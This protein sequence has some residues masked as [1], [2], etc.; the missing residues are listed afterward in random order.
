MELFTEMSELY[1][2][3]EINMYTNKYVLN[4]TSQGNRYLYSVDAKKIFQLDE[5]TYKYLEKNINNEMMLPEVIKVNQEDKSCFEYIEFSDKNFLTI[6][7]LSKL[8]LV[9]TNDC[10][11]NCS[12]CYA[13]GGSYGFKP[14]YM[15][16][17]VIDQLFRFLSENE[18][19]VK[20]LML[21]GG[22]PLLAMEQINDVMDSIQ[23]YKVGI[24]QYLM[25]TN[26]TILTDEE[27]D[28]LI[29]KNVH[30]TVSLDGNKIINDQLRKYKFNK[31][32]S[33]FDE[34][35]K[36]I[37]RF[38][39][40]GGAIESIEST[41]TKKHEMLN[42]SKNDVIN[43][44]KN[45]F[46]IENILIYDVI[47]KKRND[48]ISFTE[49]RND[50]NFLD[51]EHLHPNDLKCINKLFNISQH[52]YQI[53]EAGNTILTIL[54]NGEVYPCQLLINSKFSLGNVT[55]PFILNKEKTKKYNTMV[56]SLHSKKECENCIARN[57]C[58]Y[59]LYFKLNYSSQELCN[60]MRNGM[61]Q[62]L[63]HI[64]DNRVLE[65]LDELIR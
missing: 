45:E 49:L 53:C 5:E 4:E 37:N 59:C 44:I 61:I 46:Q 28:F 19:S 20:N 21:F 41:Y 62:D 2:N 55:E 17:Q 3:E 60:L 25:V 7:E 39:T 64:I 15:S 47:D 38:R 58:T 29:N 65:R 40:A 12:Y 22:E 32:K 14:E 34:V 33:T 42:I 36:N 1:I 31:N 6:K 9:L 18:I 51:C 27:I 30:I 43:Y 56:N 10:N 26:F 13:D 50:E 35:K 57:Y 11:L 54:S 48:D 23:K 16:H 52:N 24:N 63:D 8:V